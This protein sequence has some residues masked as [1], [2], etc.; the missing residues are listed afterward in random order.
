MSVCM[1]EIVFVLFLIVFFFIV[2]HRRLYLT[3]GVSPGLYL[4]QQGVSPGLYLTQP[5]VSP[6]LFGPF[7]FGPVNFEKVS[8]G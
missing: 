5:G 3:Q 2:A 7:T 6:G 4:T 1:S 8:Q